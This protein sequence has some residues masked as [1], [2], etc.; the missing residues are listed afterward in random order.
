MN[1][2]SDCGK[3]VIK[4][5]KFLKKSFIGE[6]FRS[7]KISVNGF[8]K[9]SLDGKLMQTLLSKDLGGNSALLPIDFFSI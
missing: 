8:K 7:K 4:W 1:R 9:I 3:N 6:M 2:T 5:K